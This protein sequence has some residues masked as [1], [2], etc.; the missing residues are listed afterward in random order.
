MSPCCATLAAACLLGLSACSSL[1]SWLNEPVPD[2][3]LTEL[4][5]GGSVVLTPPPPP[6]DPIQV[7]LPGGGAVVVTPPGSAPPQTR[8]D[9]VGRVIGGLLGAVTGNPL[10]AVGGL[11]GLRLL[12]AL[13]GAKRAA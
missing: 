12:A 7:E 8:G 3:T 2:P 11:A 4:P 5:G 10:L 13:F 9:V 1:T 6:E